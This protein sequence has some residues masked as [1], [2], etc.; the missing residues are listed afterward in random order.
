MTCPACGSPRYPEDVYCGSCGAALA[1]SES[2]RSRV[3]GEI[4]LQRGPP[5][6][7]FAAEWEFVAIA[8]DGGLL[9]RS[10]PFSANPVLLAAD[11]PP[12]PATGAWRAFH[13]L[14]QRLTAE[15]W[16]CVATGTPWHQRRCTR[17]RDVRPR[18]E[19]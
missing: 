4:V 8:D 12:P 11:R 17:A 13:D 14:Q 5:L 2:A 9:D 7:G 15:G 3:S 6:M 18:D 19:G 10:A 16:T 1:A